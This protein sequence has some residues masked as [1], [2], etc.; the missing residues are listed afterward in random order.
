MKI[1]IDRQEA[2]LEKIFPL[3][4]KRKQ[5]FAHVSAGVS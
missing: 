1:H 4:I 2:A 3:K 5:A